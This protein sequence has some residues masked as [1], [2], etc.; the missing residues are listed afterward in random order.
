MLVTTKM[1]VTASCALEKTV[2]SLTGD[3]PDCNTDTACDGK[4]KVPNSGH[5]AC[6]KNVYTLIVINVSWQL[7]LLF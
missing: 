3:A 4:T 2:K 7:I 6:G 1:E 5:T